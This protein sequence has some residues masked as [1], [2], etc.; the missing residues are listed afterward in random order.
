MSN[1]STKF[2]EGLLLGGV[3]GFIGGILF[4]PKS[5]RELR[6]DL[7]D[8]SDEIYK[9]ASTSISDFKDRGQQAMQD[10]QSKG[11]AVLKQATQQFQ[12]T[13]DQLSQKIQEMGGKSSSKVSLQEPESAQHM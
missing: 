10:F 3:L 13:R 5:G 6:K 12:E 8:G 9:Q 1:S 4:A 2:L 7:A 11:D